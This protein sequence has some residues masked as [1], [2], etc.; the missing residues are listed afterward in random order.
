LENDLVCDDEVLARIRALAIPPAW[1]DV[2]ICANPYGH[3]QATGRDV[4]GR[5]QYRYH[6]DWMAVRE[7]VKFSTLT[8]FAQVLPKLRKRVDLDLKKRG[9]PRERVIGSVVWLL[10]NTL[11]RVG[12]DSYARKNGTFGLTTLRSRHLTI[13]GSSLLF[14][15]VGKSGREWKLKLKDRRVA[16]VIRA[17]EELPGQRLFQYRDDEGILHDIH[18]QDVNAYIRDVTGDDFTS[19]HFRTWG[20]TVLAASLLAETEVPLGRRE[21]AKVLN[22]VIDAVAGVLH[23]T[24]AVC[25]SGYIHPGV[26]EAWEEKRLAAGLKAARQARRSLKGMDTTESAVFRW[27]SRSDAESCRQKRS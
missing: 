23:N 26:I 21:R 4:R 11:I 12:N 22:G 19:K 3:L 8:S 27:L 1:T 16:S 6:P 7:E 20:A 13:E 15:F 9:M 24:R 2:W 17:I 25:R 10:D 14:S 5:K 18:S